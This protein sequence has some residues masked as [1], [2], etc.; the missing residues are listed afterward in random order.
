MQ[1][2][3]SDMSGVGDDEAVRHSTFRVTAS[4][5][6]W[7]SL[8]WPF[9]LVDVSDDEI[10][11]RSIGW[12]WWVKNCRIERKRVISVTF[13]SFLGA[14]KFHIAVENGPPITLR[15]SVAVSQL[16]ESLRRHGY[17]IK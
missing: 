16:R 7:R 13:S 2:G 3:P 14:A 12:S 1:S 9:G 6:S 4:T 11:V 10:Q 17:P 8:P 5:G 15:A